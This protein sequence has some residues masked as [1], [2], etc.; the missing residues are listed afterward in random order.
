[1][2]MTERSYTES[3]ETKYRYG[4]NGKENDEDAGIIDFGER[5]YNEK[6]CRWWSLDKYAELYTPV[7]PY[8]YVA[9]SPIVYKDEDGH[10]IRIAIH[11]KNGLTYFVEYTYGDTYEAFITR[12]LG[13]TGGQNSEQTKESFYDNSESMVKLRETFISLKYIID[14]NL[15]KV[16]I[17]VKTPDELYSKTPSANKTTVKNAI[18][19]SN[20]FVRDLARHGE[21]T[22]EID[23][24]IE[25]GADGFGWL[26]NGGKRTSFGIGFAP[27]GGLQTTSG[28]IQAPAIGLLHELG[29]AYLFFKAKTSPTMNQVQ[30]TTNYYVQAMLG[31]SPAVKATNEKSLPIYNQLM[32]FWKSQE[33]KNYENYIEKIIIEQIETPAAKK[34]KQ[35]TR[36]DHGGK[37]F[38]TK[39][40]TTIEPCVPT[41]ACGCK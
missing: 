34:M 18:L 17:K 16:H 9:N 11:A 15:D 30:S 29:H 36:T 37:V 13:T 23:Y 5:A 35:G 20:H 40:S 38:P 26:E 1:M 22:V 39:G 10:I 41:S 25:C 31:K 28:T 19:K 3:Q 27:F 32:Y 2:A 33:D 4:F 7:S 8:A 14:N 21:L 12:W 24:M 6:I